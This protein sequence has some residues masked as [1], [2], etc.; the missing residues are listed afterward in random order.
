MM[1]ITTIMMGAHNR[2]KLSPH[3]PALALNQANAQ[4][5]RVFVEMV[6]WVKIN[7]AMIKIWIEEM[8]A[9]IV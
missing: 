3:T 8:A 2:V 1:E 5:L 9:T 7:N 6:S 4:S